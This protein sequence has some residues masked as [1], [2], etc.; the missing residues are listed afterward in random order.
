M[1]GFAGIFQHGLWTP[2]EPREAEI[3]REMLDSGLSAVP[4]LGGAPF[5]EKPPLFPWILAGSYS[6][7]GV[8]A[9][10]ARIPSAL[11]GIGAVL[12]AFELGRRA[13][14]RTAG[15]C[16]AAVLATSVEFAAISH[17]SVN[18]TALLFFVAAGHLAFLVA[19]DDQ[20][21]GRRS[22]ALPLAGLLAGLAFLTKAW[23][24]PILLAGP[25]L[26]AAALGREWRFLAR[27]GVRSIL[28]CVAGTVLLGA[29][30]VLALV[31]AGRSDLVRICLVDNVVGRAAGGAAYASFG[32]A[33]GPLYYL[34]A[35][36]AS[37]LP[38][39]LAIPAIVLARA[40][41]DRARFLALLVVAGLVLLSIPSG[42]RE[43]YALPL[44]PAAAAVVGVWLS[45][46]GSRRGSRIDAPTLAA[47]LGVLVLACAAG[48]LGL[49]LAA[50][51]RVPASLAEFARALDGRR[52]SGVLAVAAAAL[53][54]GGAA[55]AWFAARALRSGSPALAARTAVAAASILVFA[56]QAGLRP[57][58]DPA[59]DLRAGAL[60][61]ARAVPAPE[62][63]LGFA[64]DETI[65]AVV[66][67][68]G[69]RL[70]RSVDDP[71]SAVADLE[72]GPS[73]H[74]VVTEAGEKRLPDG[75]RRRLAPVAELRVGVARPVTV[76]RYDAAR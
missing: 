67:F 27:A 40:G 60:A 14:G 61:I 19:R 15:L 7:F 1:L 76:Y 39:T 52:A 8:S 12:V 17:A 43:L 54:L 64:L 22:L 37:F 68:Y 6:V 59:K 71:E 21:L 75:L 10:S 24:G 65:R 66:P 16:A 55:I 31:R 2:D 51:G 30:W 42:K 5:V 69:G 58:L 45:R 32:H 47:V 28:A 62:P 46:V 48:A 9:G 13:G 26:I 23:I 25:P 36:P 29:P 3:G 20:R 4:T 33:R 11:F 63:L 44:F 18:D 34:S 70:I 49:A 73:R 57:I 35:F 74:L 38:W 41:R 72:S 50:A 56:L 53:A